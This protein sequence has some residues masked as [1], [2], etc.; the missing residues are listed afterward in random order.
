MHIKIFTLQVCFIPSTGLCSIF[1]V[2]SNLC[3]LLILMI[4]SKHLVALIV[5]SYILRILQ[6]EVWLVSL[7][8]TKLS[9]RLDKWNSIENGVFSNFG[10]ALFIRSTFQRLIIFQKKINVANF[11]LCCFWI[12]CFNCCNIWGINSNWFDLFSVRFIATAWEKEK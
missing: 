6:I 2:F 10:K 1:T 9:V 11:H 8:H 4:N 12:Q 7:L 3:S 5:L